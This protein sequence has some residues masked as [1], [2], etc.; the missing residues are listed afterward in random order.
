MGTHQRVFM[1]FTL[2]TVLTL[3]PIFQLSSS[4]KTW[5]GPCEIDYSLRQ[6]KKLN[7]WSQKTNMCVG[8]LKI[9][10]VSELIGLPKSNL[11]GKATYQPLDKCKI[12]NG[13]APGLRA[14]PSQG[15]NPKHPGP[16]TR[17]MFLPFSSPDT[18]ANTNP[19][20]DYGAYFAF[21]RDWL[22]Y[23]NESNQKQSFDFQK[24]YVRLSFNVG[25]FKVSHGNDNGS[26]AFGKK[27]TAE[28]D[29][30][31]DFSKT[32]IVLVI[33]PAGTPRGYF[34][35]GA[36]GT[37]FV[38]GHDVIFMSVPPATYTTKFVPDFPMIAPQEWLHELYHV[39]EFSLQHHSGTE[40]WQNN[41]G[42]DSSFPGMGEW[43]LMNMSKTDLLG[44]EKWIIGYL[45][46]D[47]VICINSATKT[48]HWLVPSGARVD[49]H[50]LAVI[51]LTANKVIVLESIRNMGLNYKLHPKS[52][53]LL[54]WTV[55]TSDPRETFGVEAV[56]PKGRKVGKTPFVLF[57]A[58]LKLG[59]SVSVEG[60]EIKVIER[61]KFGDVFE[62]SP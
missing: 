21:L 19:V 8:P 32:D 6:W 46:D 56:L 59:E 55:D 7:E 36:L 10:K 14:F 28:V 24:D 27:F 9:N 22:S 40:Y 4:A 16:S 57:D 45:R 62:V 2:F 51:P 15:W 3:T 60:I 41:R 30:Q 18:K 17:Y 31:I 42:K 58:P 29:P 12:T 50:K 44:W 39:G 20:T 25:D 26:R 52:Q 38:D 34:E 11:G 35:Q 33:P 48:R 53:G 43:G 5:S 61:G 49:G 37:Y 54:V 1:C 47:Q 13:T 23:I